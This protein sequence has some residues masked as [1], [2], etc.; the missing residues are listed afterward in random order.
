LEN[1]ENLRKPSVSIVLNI[2]RES[3]FLHQ[4]LYTLNA[5]VGHAHDL[6]VELIAVFDNSDDKTRE[7]FAST[8]KNKFSTVKVSEVKYGSLGLSRNHGINLASGEYIWTADADD[9]VSENSLEELWKTSRESKN[10]KSVFFT[11]YLLAFNDPYH[12]AK[13]FPSSKVHPGDF[14]FCNPYISRIFLR[15]SILL[16]FPY[17]SWDKSDTF[18]YEDWDLNC[19][20]YAAGYQ[21]QIAKSTLIYYRQRE[22]GLLKSSKNGQRR[23]APHNELFA[24]FRYLSIV[25]AWESRHNNW[26][27]WRGREE[28]GEDLSSKTLLERDAPELYSEIKKMANLVEPSIEPWKLSETKPYLPLVPGKELPEAMGRM[29]RLV[30]TSSFDEVLLLPNLGLGGA[31]KYLLN[32]AK[33]LKRTKKETRFL[34]ITGE[35]ADSHRGLIN[36]PPDFVFCD[37]I[38]LNPRLNTEDRDMLLVRL[39]LAVGSQ[40]TRIHVKPSTFG[41]RI[42]EN[43][44]HILSETF[45]LI[46]YRFSDPRRNFEDQFFIDPWAINFLRKTHDYFDTIICDCKFMLDSEKNFFPSKSEKYKLLY[47]ECVPDVEQTNEHK[48]RFKVLWASRFSP[49]KRPELMIAIAKLL[50]TVDP[51]ITIHAFGDSGRNG[52]EMV[53]SS[54]LRFMGPF[55]NFSALIRDGYD[56]FLYTSLYDGLPNVVVE[57]LMSNLPVVSAEVGGVAEVVN[58]GLNGLL[59]ENENTNTDALTVKYVQAIVSIYN[60]LD[61]FRL[62]CRESKEMLKAQH[63]REQFDLSVTKIFLAPQMHA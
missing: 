9:L 26:M 22:T 52:F 7:S 40:T 16:D 46:Y 2:H 28:R 11:E 13:Y 33:S 35:P 21:F 31:E 27:F 10:P 5:A 56:M 29:L 39:L 51:R 61:A 49:E 60:D 12:L 41:H 3:D 18:A 54:N 38:N 45:D 42:V 19:R 15:R 23:I 32:I 24:P 63:G 58:D 50:K 6:V 44:G 20:L 17:G 25:S 30:G 4:T 62:R 8:T 55:S 37:F 57:A 43:Y 59:I 47:N 36:L 48:R 53:S 1:N 34:F 14:V